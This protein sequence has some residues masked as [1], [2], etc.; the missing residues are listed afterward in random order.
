MRKILATKV[1]VG[2]SM[3]PTATKFNPRQPAN[4]TCTAPNQFIY[5]LESTN[6]EDLKGGP[7]RV[8]VT[9]FNPLA[10]GDVEWNVGTDVRTKHFSEK[11]NLPSRRVIGIMT[12]DGKVEGDVPAGSFPHWEFMGEGGTSL[13]ELESRAA[14]NRAA[15]ATPKKAD[16]KTAA[17]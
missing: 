11:K 4:S 13:E 3:L 9:S 8:A 17:A 6:P 16:A 5:I 1:L 12:P 2:L 7:Q 15:R 14:K 10:D